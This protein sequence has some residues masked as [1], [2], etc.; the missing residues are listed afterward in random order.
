MSPVEKLLRNRQG[1]S[2]RVASSL[3]CLHR[4]ASDCDGT[5]R[6]SWWNRFLITQ[7][8]SRGKCTRRVRQVSPAG[9]PELPAAWWPSPTHAPKHTERPPQTS[10]TRA[11]TPGRYLSRA[12]GCLN[13]DVPSSAETPQ[14]PPQPARHPLLWLRKQ[15][16]ET[17]VT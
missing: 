1:P 5:K 11:V 9:R 16:V 12:P 2:S 15:E 7:R 3:F 4:R 13:R 6:F 8:K 14:T 17:P 10:E